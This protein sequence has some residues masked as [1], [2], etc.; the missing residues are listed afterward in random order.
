MEAYLNCVTESSAFSRLELTDEVV[1][2]YGD[3]A[4]KD[5]KFTGIAVFLDDTMRDSVSLIGSGSRN[6]GMRKG[7]KGGVGVALRIKNTSLAFLNCHL[8]ANDDKIRREQILSLSKKM[9]A[10]LGAKV[11][12]TRQFHHVVWMGDLNYRLHTINHEKILDMLRDGHLSELHE[13]YDG[14][15]RDRNEHQVFNGYEEPR[16]VTTFYPSYKKRKNRGYVEYSSNNKN[17]PHEVYLTR[18]PV[19]LYKQIYKRKTEMTR[20]PG[21]TDRILW[22]TM[23]LPCP[24]LSKFVPE[25]IVDDGIVTDN[26]R[27]VN[28]G[29]GMDVS[30]HSPVSCT[31]CLT[32]S[33]S[34]DKTSDPLRRTPLR[35]SCP[36]TLETDI[37]VDHE[38]NDISNLR[39]SES[40]PCESFS[41]D[42]LAIDARPNETYD[43]QRPASGPS[44]HESVPNTD[45]PVDAAK[46]EKS[47]KGLLGVALGMT[48]RVVRNTNGV[49]KGIDRFRAGE[50]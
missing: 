20:N 23:K 6:F 40:L 24:I 13:K 47:S 28:N 15:G 43:S 5:Q 1:Y 42:D 46:P 18:Y 11:P 4:F 21:W 31:F 32:L 37:A 41:K 33:P 50:R 44:M 48:N 19:P 38:S 26:Y 7:S 49:I 9:G 36:S 35:S 30:D 8:E 16:K 14:L 3:G 22:H 25:E 45:L 10:L 34:P 39:V 27:S 12:L 2:G 29:I 17:W